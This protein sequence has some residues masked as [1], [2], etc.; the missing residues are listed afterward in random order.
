MYFKSA[1]IYVTSIPL[2]NT[3]HGNSYIAVLKFQL[4]FTFSE[5]PLIC[6]D[7]DIVYHLNIQS[8]LIRSLWPEHLLAKLKKIR[9]KTQLVDH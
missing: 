9:R 2:L 8:V 5:I 1:S 4:R 3:F 6:H 7:K